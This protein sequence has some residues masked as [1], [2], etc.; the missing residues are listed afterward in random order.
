MPKDEVK[1]L[2]DGSTEVYGNSEGEITDGKGQVPRTKFK[3][4]TWY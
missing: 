2:L 4:Q 3:P 1:G